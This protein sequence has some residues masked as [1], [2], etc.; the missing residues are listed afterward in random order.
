MEPLCQGGNQGCKSLIP[1]QKLKFERNIN[2]LKLLKEAFIWSIAVI[3]ITIL[4]IVMFISIPM[5]AI[6]IFSLLILIMAIGVCLTPVIAIILW[7][8]GRD[9]KRK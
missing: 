4:L 8:L 5:T 7:V 9:G 2:M 6:F 3:L 1:L